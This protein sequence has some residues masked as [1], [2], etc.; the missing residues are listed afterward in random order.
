M[1]IAT[2]RQLLE[3]GIHFGHQT[4]RWHPKMARYIYGQRNGIYI[5]DLQQTLRQLYRAYGLVR[6]AVEQGG[7]VL[8]VGTK[9]QGQE[10]VQ[11]EAKRCGMYY[12]TNRWL[13]GTLTNYRTVAQSIAE[14]DK[15]Q[16]METDGSI[17]KYAKKEGVM[18]RKRRAKLEKNLLGIQKMPGLP[19]V[20]FVVDAGREDIAVREARRLGIPCIG[21]VDTNCD[22]DVVDLPIPGNDDAIRAV[23]LF[24]SVMA[25]AVLEGKMRAEKRRADEQGE[26]KDEAP[27]EPVEEAAP[28]AA[29]ADQAEE[30]DEAEAVE[31]P[32][33]EVAEE[34]APEAP[35]EAAVEAAA[36][37]AAPEAPAEAAA[38]EAEAEVVAPVVE[39]VSETEEATTAEEE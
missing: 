27:E 8:F 4:R 30:A 28:A 11:R 3:A 19:K 22:P 24:C 1:A 38:P 33:P 37:E 9:R 26:N 10:A 15:L 29:E 13:G 20:V 5:I 36:P 7:T 32:A 17:E 18:M 31:A 6:N 23:S 2:M 34:A 35:P 16:E 12:V 25:D 14:L 39:I 21:V